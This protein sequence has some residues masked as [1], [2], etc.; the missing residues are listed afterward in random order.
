MGKATHL[1]QTLRQ[2][3]N[4]IRLFGRSLKILWTAAPQETSFML[5]SLLLQSII[6][7]LSVWINKQVVDTITHSASGQ[8]SQ[9]GMFMAGALVAAWIVS[10][11]IESLLNPWNTA[12]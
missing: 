7:A 5:I 4:F 3:R 12:I 6:P 9:S 8:A 2:G 1:R 11:L 10:L